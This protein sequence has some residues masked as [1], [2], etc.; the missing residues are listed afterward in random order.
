[1]PGN[2]P[3]TPTLLAQG[4]METL[5][6]PLAGAV[7]PLNLPTDHLLHTHLSAFLS[8]NNEELEKDFLAVLLTLS[9]E[10]NNL[11]QQDSTLV[12]QV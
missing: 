5:L 10:N 3:S 4:L 9:T 11:K 8:H 6:Q 2:R 7:A 1:M 12:A